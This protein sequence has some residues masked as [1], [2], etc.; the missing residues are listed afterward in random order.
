MLAQSDTAPHELPEFDSYWDLFAYNFNL[1]NQS[2]LWVE[3]IRQWMLVIAS[4]GL[5]YYFV[6]CVNRL[7]E[8][9]RERDLDQCV[10]LIEVA[11]VSKIT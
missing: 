11:K 2:G 8:S 3:C 7:K 1:F 10:L 4:V 9:Q 5:S 6:K